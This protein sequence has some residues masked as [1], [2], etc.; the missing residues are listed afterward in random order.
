MFLIVIAMLLWLVFCSENM[1]ALE[2]L[3]GHLWF[4]SGDHKILEVFW[5]MLSLDVCRCAGDIGKTNVDTMKIRVLNIGKRNA[6]KA[7]ASGGAGDLL[8][9]MNLAKHK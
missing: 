2:D 6:F 9:T 8:F 5:V 7:V 3:Y 4:S 1:L